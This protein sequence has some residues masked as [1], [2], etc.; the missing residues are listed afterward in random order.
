MALALNNGLKPTDKL[1]DGP[2]NKWS[3]RNHDHY[4]FEYKDLEWC[5]A[6]SPNVPYFNM[7]ITVNVSQTIKDFE[8]ILKEIGAD[9]G[10]FDQNITLGYN[11][12]SIFDLSRLYLALFNDGQLK[13][14]NAYAEHELKSLPIFKSQNANQVK[15]WLRATTKYGTGKHLKSL[16]PANDTFYSKSGTSNINANTGWYVLA[17]DDILIVSMVTYMNPNNLEDPFKDRPSIPYRSG[18]KTAGYFSLYFMKEL[19][20]TRKE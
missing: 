10:P 5:L 1:Y 12:I 6:E 7:P 15:E 20:K 8:V 16:L 3:P 18:A 11:S 19:L 4:T 14:L 13:N 9:A 2:R 17:N